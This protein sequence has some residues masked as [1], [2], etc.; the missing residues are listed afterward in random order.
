MGEKMFQR[1][2]YFYV[3]KIMLLNLMVMLQKNFLGTCIS[4]KICLHIME[5]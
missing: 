5:N 1:I 3:P 4:G 2:L